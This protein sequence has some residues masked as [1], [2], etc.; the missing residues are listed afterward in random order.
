MEPNKFLKNDC[1]INQRRTE[2][3]QPDIRYVIAEQSL[4]LIKNDE[5]IACI[6]SSRQ[7]KLH[8]GIHVF[9]TDL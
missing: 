2:S 4:F 7:E 8:A 1:L 3:P 5:T 6:S 9:F